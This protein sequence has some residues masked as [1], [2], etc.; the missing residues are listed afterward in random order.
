MRSILILFVVFAAGIFI[1][2]EFWPDSHD[3]PS[4]HFRF[5]RGRLPY[6]APAIAPS[7]TPPPI[8]HGRILHPPFNP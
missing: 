7:P 8:S 1:G 5:H 4:H 6:S 3:D 2:G